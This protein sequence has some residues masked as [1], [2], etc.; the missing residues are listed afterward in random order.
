M[1]GGFGETSTLSGVS[2]GEINR[3]D[4]ERADGL[5]LDL[6]DV[7]RGEIPRAHEAGEL[8]RAG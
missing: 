6:G 7:D 3:Q 1:N 4:R 8:H 5:V 2:V